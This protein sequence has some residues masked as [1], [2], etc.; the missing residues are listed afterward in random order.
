MPSQI[1]EQLMQEHGLKAKQRLVDLMI[2]ATKRGDQVQEK[3][4]EQVRT[5]LEALTRSKG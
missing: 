1:A 4:L 3:L 5:H 2:D